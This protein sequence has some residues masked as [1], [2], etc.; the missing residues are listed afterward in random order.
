MNARMLLL[1]VSLG[2]LSAPAWPKDSKY[3]PID[4][5]L[6]PRDA[7]IALARS[8][9]PKSMS[10]RATIKVLTRSGYEVAHRGDNDCVCLVMRGWSAIRFFPA[11]GRVGAYDSKLRAPICFDPIAARTILP[12]EELRANLGI[13]GV[14]PDEIAAQV[15]M[16]YALGK[17]PKM[18]GVQFGY[19]WSAD[20]DVGVEDAWHPHMMIYAPYYKNA[21]LG[22]HGADS[23]LPSVVIDEGGPFALVV[24]AVPDKLAIRPETPQGTAGGHH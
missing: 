6:M 20:Q 19:M 12:Q 3:P 5:Y 4:A 23:G 10:A 15:S 18:E 9:A 22:G 24:V 16:A 21:M 2:V 1:V 8:A 14:A 13:E 17:L 11:D 7:E